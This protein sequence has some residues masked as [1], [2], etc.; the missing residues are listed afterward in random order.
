MGKYTIH[1]SKLFD[2]KTKHVQFDMSVTVD[3][4]TGEVVKV[5]QRSEPLPE[6]II[7]PDVDLRGKFVCP[8]FVDA[9]THIFLHAYDETPS[10]AAEERRELRGTNL[11]SSEPLSYRTASRLHDVQVPAPDHLHPS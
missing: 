11:T 4:Q 1:T 3:E 8:G 5:V 7:A 2:P 6:S 10:L 9:H